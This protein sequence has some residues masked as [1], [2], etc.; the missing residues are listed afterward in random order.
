METAGMAGAVGNA[1]MTNAVVACLLREI[2]NRDSNPAVSTLNR[3]LRMR[4]S[5]SLNLT[6]VP[7]PRSVISL[8]AGTSRPHFSTAKRRRPF[9]ARSSWAQAPRLSRSSPRTLWICGRSSWRAPWCWELAVCASGWSS[10]RSGAATA[11]AAAAAA[12]AASSEASPRT[13]LV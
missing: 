1:A 8:G 2:T 3:A 10:G 6:G 9:H 13:I 11:A 7:Y 12:A 5:P 4:R